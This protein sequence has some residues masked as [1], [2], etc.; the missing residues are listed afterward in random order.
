MNNFFKYLLWT[1]LIS[2]ISGQLHAALRV[3]TTTQDLAAIAKAI[4]GQ[5]IEVHSLTPG[6]RDPHYAV[7]KPSMIR[8]VFRADLLLVIGADMEIGWLPPLLQS[9]RNSRVQPGNPGYLDLS[10]VVTLLGK[11]RGSISRA[12]GDVHAKGNPHYWLDPRNGVYMAKA[13]TK[14]LA[15]LDPEH[16]TDYTTN[17]NVFKSKINRK[18]PDWKKALQHLKGKPVI[19]YHNS[20]VYLANAFDFNIADE[21]EPKPG[22]APSA[23][24]LSSLIAEIKMKQID[25]LLIE[26]YYER[27]S[28]HYL[29]QQTGVQVAVVPQSVGAQ[30]NIHDY[31]DLFDSI[32]D[33]LQLKEDN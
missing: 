30:S 16:A 24:S 11:A 25:L 8:R 13:I 6:T 18:L 14:R 22:I 33:V 10:E 20:F 1:A 23:S 28:A 7:A 32:I 19:T 17:F 2:L 21:V 5:H 27:R 15:Q 29:K 26:P 12:M 31:V 4:G 3:E 9:S